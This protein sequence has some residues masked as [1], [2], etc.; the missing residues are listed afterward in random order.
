MTGAPRAAALCVLA[1]LALAAGG[2]RAEDAVKIGIVAPVSGPFAE[3]V[4]RNA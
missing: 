2:A 1:A 4:R 3:P